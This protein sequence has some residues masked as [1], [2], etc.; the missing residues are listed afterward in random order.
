MRYTPWI[1]SEHIP[2]MSTLENFVKSPCFA[3]K[4]GEDLAVA[5]WG[6]MVDREL[7]IF[8]YC[9]PQEALWQKD[10]NDPLQIMNVY[11]YTICH[12][13]AHVLAQI[14]N[15]AGLKGRV[16][17]I[18]GHEGTEMYY[19]GQ[20]H[21]FDGDIQMFH[22]LRPPNEQVIASR[23]QLYEDPSLVDDQPNPSNP[24]FFPDRHPSKMRSSYEVKPTYPELLN[25]QIHSMDFRLRPGEEISRIFH[26]R[27]RWHVFDPHPL[28]FTRY[29]RETGPE[30]PTERF[31][32]RRQWGNG[33]F[34]YHPKLDPAFRDVELGAE[35]V[36]GLKLKAD[37]GLVC[38]GETGHVLFAFESPYI[39]CGV[40]D[41]WKRLPSLQGAL[42]D[43]TL[44]LPTG[45]RARVE[46][47]AYQPGTPKL[48][49]TWETVWTSE[50]KTGT[51]EEQ[52]DFTSLADGRFNL[53]LRIVLEGKGAALKDFETRMWFMVSPHSLPAL[54]AK[55]ENRMSLHSGDRYGLNTRTV[56][57]ERRL[58]YQAPD[59]AVA[60][61]NLRYDPDDFALTLPKDDT[62][63]WELTYKIEAPDGG[64][65]AWVT[66]YF[67]IESY[68]P[69]EEQDGVPAKVE[70]SSSPDGPWTVLNEYPVP[71]E[72]HGYHFG[73][74]GE[75]R[76]EEMPTAAYVRFSARKG[77]R[78]LR[79][80]GHYVPSK[81]ADPGNVPLEVE[82]VW[83]EDDPKV[84]R[85]K[86]TH[87]E[88]VEG[89]EHEYVVNCENTPHSEEINLRVPSLPR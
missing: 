83:Y 37:E 6:W 8:H 79:I 86:K 81:H 74:F 87:V 34:N 82:H 39:Y 75:H 22:R 42:L 38:E 64:K 45:A 55:G 24:Y 76:F 78:G 84:G 65:M 48:A 54:K 31:W 3:G 23:E 18:K 29:R 2:D 41:P 20:W 36:N 88:R 49:D 13:H 32:P 69:D 28:A 59:D 40:P 10:G 85:R 35:E 71:V 30:G 73:N 80:A 46:G 19:D 27:G 53:R 17:N 52:A 1:V 63:P 62:S 47:S 72:D 26:N 58:D 12:V 77:M 61:K 67:Y 50:D 15:A 25:E 70:I 56:L 33:F 51:I 14:A 44:E 7:G 21:Y 60:S 89:L 43:L 68:K 66:A 16:G 5:L 11:G 9:P 57:L 4:Q